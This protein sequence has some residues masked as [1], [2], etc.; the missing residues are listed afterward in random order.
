MNFLYF[1]MIF[2]YFQLISIGLQ[3]FSYIFKWFP[4]FFFDFLLFLNN[5]LD[6]KSFFI[7]FSIYS[8]VSPQANPAQIIMSKARLHRICQK[9]I[10][11]DRIWSLS[12]IGFSTR[13]GTQKFIPKAHLHRVRWKS[14]P[15][16]RIWL[17]SSMDFFRRSEPKKSAP[18]L[19]SQNLSKK[20]PKWSDLITF[21]NVFLHC[22][23]RPKNQFKSSPAQAPL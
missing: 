12:S 10:P 4:L 6:F 7:S 5:Y 8:F 15:D 23:R 20:N 17:F 3:W 18:K 22:D 2:L 19:A 1:S 9:Y 21:V 11:G 16:V 13:I 14:V